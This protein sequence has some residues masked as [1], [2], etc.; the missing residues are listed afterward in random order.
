MPPRNPEENAAKEASIQ[1]ALDGLKTGEHTSAYSAAKAHG[2]SKST[3]LRRLKGEKPST[4]A[5]EDQQQLSDAEEHVLL[6]WITKLTATGYP[7]MHNTIR[8]MAEEIRKDRVESL[9][10]NNIQLVEY[11]PLGCYWVHNFIK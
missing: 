7:P 1:L 8:E 2:I 6:K 4:R 3:L 9:N 11:P 10:D 5:H